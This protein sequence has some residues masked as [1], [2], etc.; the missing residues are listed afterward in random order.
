M[1]NSAA[2]V[3][4]HATPIA[5]PPA[6]PPEWARHK[7]LWIGFPS[8]A[9]EWLEDL[10]PARAEVAGLINALSDQ[11][12]MRVLVDGKEALAAAARLV[13]P[14][15]EIVPAQLGDIW[16]RDTGPIFEGSG[17]RGFEV[18]RLKSSLPAT[19]QPR[20]P[21]AHLF[22]FNGW[23]GKY[24]MAGDAGVNRC[25][26]E[27]AG[28][29]A[30]THDFILEGGSIDLDGEGAC[31]T[32]RQCL[33][34]KNRNQGWDQQKAENALKE[35]LNLTHILWL[36]EGLAGDHTDGHIDNI[37]RFIAPGKVLCQSPA[38][39]DDPNATVLKAIERALG[40]MRD[41]AGRKLEVIAL[42]SP[43]RV[44]GKDGEP[45]AASHMNFIIANGRIALP[46]YND[47]AADA[48][49]MLAKCFPQ[50]QI[51][52]LSARAVLTGGGAFHCITQ[53]QPE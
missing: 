12:Q 9:R 35:A 23:G 28:V 1:K 48:A 45:M 3:P 51:V 7:A 46:A 30:V 32:T 16:L 47:R 29:M 41:A 53:Q 18:S 36:D 43:G 50:H 14:P 6:I 49:A 21:A 2:P 15:A 13:R 25:I 26:A 39:A 27:K 42:P 52:P 22:R 10:E 11:E 31:L 38:G 37:A 20:S 8:H 24:V 40:A 44:N 17:F 4:D 5:I 33:L 34:N 19:A